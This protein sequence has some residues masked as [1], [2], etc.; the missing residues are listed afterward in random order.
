MSIFLMDVF[1]TYPPNI[2]VNAKGITNNLVVLIMS[3]LLPFHTFILINFLLE[4]LKTAFK[5]YVKYGILLS[6]KLK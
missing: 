3:S 2:I 6:F 5:Y 4:G 1:P